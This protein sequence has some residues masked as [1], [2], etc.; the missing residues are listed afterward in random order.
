MF[1]RRSSGRGDS[2]R[3]PLPL[4]P[5][6]TTNFQWDEVKPLSGKPYCHCVLS[7]TNLHPRY[8]MMP[9]MNL[10]SKLPSIEVPTILIYG[11]KSWDRCI[12]DKANTRLLVSQAGKSLLPTTIS[13]LEMLAFFSSWKAVTRKSSWKFKFLENDHRSR[14]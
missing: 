2:G 10:R 4:L 3:V 12:M 13:G 11:G 9:V 1:S 14:E 8:Y 6:P 5:D 7:P